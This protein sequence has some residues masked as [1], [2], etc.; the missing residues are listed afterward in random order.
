MKNLIICCLLFISASLFGQ[1]AFNDCAAICLDKVALVKDYSPRSSCAIEQDATGKLAVY[2]VNISEKAI[3]PKRNIDFKIAIRDAATKTI[4]MYSE[5]T[6]ETI[7]V[8]DIL[9]KCKKDDHILL[10][11]V[12]RSF[13]LPHNEILVK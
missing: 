3:T 5:R 1:N 11:T 10:M 2:T 7:A 4:W 12:D 13:A 8:E 6:F 9:A